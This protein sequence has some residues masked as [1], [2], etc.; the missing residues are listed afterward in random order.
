MAEDK[1]R[2][3]KLDGDAKDFNKAIDSAIKKMGELNTALGGS[4][5]FEF[6]KSVEQSMISG[7]D[8]VIKNINGKFEGLFNSVSNDSKGM[9]NNVARGIA[10]G[11]FRAFDA[12]KIQ[13]TFKEAGKKSGDSFGKSF[14]TGV[15]DEVKNVLKGISAEMTLPQSVRM[16]MRGWNTPMSTQRP[17]MGVNFGGIA[18]FKPSGQIMSSE[19]DVFLKHRSPRVAAMGE[20]IRKFHEEWD[21]TVRKTK[22]IMD[23]FTKQLRGAVPS[24][25]KTA[26]S[27]SEI[28]AGFRKLDSEIRRKIIEEEKKIVEEAMMDLRRAHL[29]FGRVQ[30]SNLSQFL[31]QQAAVPVGGAIGGGI[32]SSMSPKVYAESSRKFKELAQESN[33]TAQ[34][35]AIDTKKISSSMN[36]MGNKTEASVGK[37]MGALQRLGFI[38]SRVM[39]DMSQQKTKVEYVMRTIERSFQEVGWRALAFAGAVFYAFERVAHIT[40][41]YAINLERMVHLTGFAVEESSRW[42]AVFKIFGVEMHTGMNAIK[43]FARTLGDA[44]KGIGQGPKLFNELGI[45]IKSQDGKLMDF[46]E[47]MGKTTEALKHIDTYSQKSRIAMHLF[48]RQFHEIL[49]FLDAGGEKLNKYMSMIEKTGLVMSEKGMESIRILRENLNLLSA[50]LLGLALQIGKALSPV[51]EYLTDKIVSLIS[52]VKNHEALTKWGVIMGSVGVVISGVVF[53]LTSFIAHV[54]TAGRVMVVAKW[55]TDSIK[56]A[57]GEAALAM[58]GTTMAI[59]AQTVALG[60]LAIAQA[61]V[62]SGATSFPGGKATISG[63]GA[64]SKADANIILDREKYALNEANKIRRAEEFAILGTWKK[65]A[66]ATP[67]P[68]QIP[69][70]ITRFTMEGEKSVGVWSKLV[71]VLKSAWTWITSLGAT[72]LKFIKIWGPWAILITMVT[73]SIISFRK[74]ID[75]LDEQ[76][77]RIDEEMKFGERWKEIWD[78]LVVS[79]Q[80][81]WEGL[82]GGAS[83]FSSTF[84]M[85]G[86]NIMTAWVGIKVLV[87]DTFELGVKII[88]RLAIETEALSLFINKKAKSYGDAR[89]QAE[90]NFDKRMDEI[91]SNRKVKIEKDIEDEKKKRD[92]LLKY[93]GEKSANLKPKDA[94]DAVLGISNVNVNETEKDKILDDLVEKRMVKEKTREKAF[95]KIYL[96]GVEELE[97]LNKRRNKLIEERNAIESGKPTNIQEKYDKERILNYKNAEIVAVRSMIKEKKKM[98]EENSKLKFSMFSREETLDMVVQSEKMRMRADMEIQAWNQ[99]MKAT[100]E[101]AAEVET[102]EDAMKLSRNLSGTGM[103]DETQLGRLKEIVEAKIGITKEG[104]ATE[105]DILNQR[106]EAEKFFETELKNIRDR[107]LKDTMDHWKMVVDKGNVGLGKLQDITSNYIKN[108]KLDTEQINK[109]NQWKSSEASKIVNNEMAS[110]KQLYL[111]NKITTG[112]YID[113]LK[114]IGYNINKYVGDA[115]L[116]NKTDQEMNKVSKDKIRL[117]KEESENIRKIIMDRLKE[118]MS[119]EEIKNINMRINSIKVY[120]VIQ[121][122]VFDA[123]K[124]GYMSSEEALRKLG[125]A[126]TEYSKYKEKKEIDIKKF[127]LKSKKEELS[128]LE[129]ESKESI[130]KLQEDLLDA[131]KRGQTKRVYEIKMAL[132]REKEI[133]SNNIRETKEGIAQMQEDIASSQNQ[134]I[135]SNSIKRIE[136]EADINRQIN[137]MRKNDSAN[138]EQELKDQIQKYKDAGVEKARVEE[139]L[140]E[141][142]QE[143]R[144][145]MFQ[146]ALD[147]S[148]AEQLFPADQLINYL[149]KLKLYYVD[150]ANQ[151]TVM[152]SAWVDAYANVKRINEEIDKLKN[153]VK[154]ITDN[155]KEW[156]DL[157]KKPFLT[158]EEMGRLTQLDWEIP[159]SSRFGK[160]GT[161]TSTGLST[162]PIPGFEPESNSGKTKTI[163]EVVASLKQTLNESSDSFSKNFESLGTSTYKLNRLFDKL[164]TTLSDILL[165]GTTVT[166]NTSTGVSG[167]GKQ[168]GAVVTT[169]GGYPNQV[170]GASN[171]NTG[172]TTVTG[173]SPDKT[174]APEPF[175]QWWGAGGNQPGAQVYGNM[176]RINK[177]MQYPKTPS[178]MWRDHPDKNTPN[179][180]QV[181]ITINGSEVSADSDL[182]NAISTLMRKSKSAGISAHSGSSLAGPSGVKDLPISIGLS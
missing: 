164:S 171:T 137:S 69:T 6:P 51:L 153:G 173:S 16:E 89:V 33:R 154:D 72:V 12:N 133:S 8:R 14:G 4:I 146:A 105:I 82:A 71:N 46:A 79:V 76:L 168:V 61:V 28:K 136:A 159:M 94:I 77:K 170:G 49:P 56:K 181:T 73:T 150:I 178:E 124:S 93:G 128:E 25:T 74:S 85:L 19:M 5:K 135:S 23:E 65:G 95:S 91:R 102:F 34:L 3:F 110:Q 157:K 143:I 24:S 107:E 113:N 147:F 106:L 152:N 172:A 80:M 10:D 126:E 99:V 41:E 84:E 179:S 63:S 45:S 116:K 175:S 117:L 58:N 53:I 67:I 21:K 163:D 90:E 158:M 167:I 119:L 83:I 88:R 130:S 42:L 64:Y 1:N 11:F 20:S 62:N 120:G 177:N 156:S 103:M 48:G 122:K 60:E 55:T 176:P 29:G 66:S 78:K 44:Q 97:E 50:T 18:A 17:N 36:D 75:P 59:Q 35:V 149:E 134:F 32:S 127:N 40:G 121:S 92:I 139:W 57:M 68:K 15:S 22:E 132:N 165:N 174:K 123:Q 26:D 52:F 96:D 166:S 47:A 161:K 111:S 138:L 100:K 162:P 9:G 13:V 87:T 148:I 31:M 115:N 131:T 142:V 140:N 43:I 129:R 109:I 81:L 125:T 54:L 182:K 155:L 27:T 86:F 151:Q 98:L 104:D 2:I 38:F 145:E 180:T 160:P 114:K 39:E 37:S 30:T 101:A 118:K 144:K 108:H 112:E 169:A 70:I 141:R 7:F